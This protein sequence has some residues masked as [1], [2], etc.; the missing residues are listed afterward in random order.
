M[1]FQYSVWKVTKGKV[2]LGD[3]CLVC[4]NTFEIIVFRKQLVSYGKFHLSFFVLHI[5]YITF[6]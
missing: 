6:L 2:D 4:D 1:H 3:M 5:D